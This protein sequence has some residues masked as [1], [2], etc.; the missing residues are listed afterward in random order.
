MGKRVAWFKVD[1]E[2]HVQTHTYIVQPSARRM[3]MLQKQSAQKLEASRDFLFGHLRNII[4]IVSQHL[5]G[6]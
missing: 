4:I 5:H 3:T 1:A 6:R 2:V